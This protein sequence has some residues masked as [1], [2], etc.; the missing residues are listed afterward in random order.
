MQTPEQVFNIE[1]GTNL[2]CFIANKDQL[3]MALLLQKRERVRERVSERQRK[4]EKEEKRERETGR[5]RDR[6]THT[7]THRDEGKERVCF[8][9][10][11]MCVF[12]KRSV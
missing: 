8:L 11:S 3:F 2:F 12:L 4:R 10:V 9:G 7:H 5:K 1:K 6:D